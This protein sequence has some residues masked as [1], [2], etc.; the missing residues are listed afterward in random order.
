M[1]KKSLTVGTIAFVFALHLP[2]VLADWYFFFWWY[3]V[4]MHALGGLAMGFLGL[5]IWD[6]LREEQTLR[7]GKGVL[8]SLG[9]VCGFVAL[10]GIGWEWA[11]GILDAF[12]L[13]RIGLLDAQLG[14]ADTMFDLFF[15]LVGGALA[16]IFL[17]AF[18]EHSR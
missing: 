12:L 5:L 3:D 13:P 17:R 18:E 7:S 8:L 15:D 2:A 4:L 1:L 11:E 6:F 14:L 9:F 10:V 16:W